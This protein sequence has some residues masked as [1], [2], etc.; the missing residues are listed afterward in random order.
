MKQITFGDLQS[1]RKQRISFEHMA[2]WMDIKDTWNVDERVYG[3]I[4]ELLRVQA[5]TAI[6]EMH[7]DKAVP[8]VVLPD[9]V[10]YQGASFNQI[11]KDVYPEGIFVND[12][13]WGYT[14]GEPVKAFGLTISHWSERESALLNDQW[15]INTDTPDRDCLEM[16]PTSPDKASIEVCTKSLVDNGVLMIVSKGHVILPGSVRYYLDKYVQVFCDVYIK[17]YDVSLLLGYRSPKPNNK[18]T[19]SVIESLAELEQSLTSAVRVPTATSDP[20]PL[21]TKPWN[22]HMKVP[23]CYEEE[24]TI[25]RSGNKVKLVFKEEESALY[26]VGSVLSQD[27]DPAWFKAT[28][29]L[30]ERYNFHNYARLKTEGRSLQSIML[31]R[32]DISLTEDPSVSSFI[33]RLQKTTRSSQLAYP[34]NS[35]VDRQYWSIGPGATIRSKDKKYKVLYSEADVVT[36]KPPKVT[37]EEVTDAV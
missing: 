27:I 16:S 4:F 3:K 35:D 36:H 28:A 12:N 33:R 11:L 22:I 26:W 19:P 32:D 1:A 20:R 24:N 13:V 6:L 9:G 8:T 17:E 18:L 7:A 14:R 31:L 21:K 15:T 23:E 30:S 34:Q 10:F 29:L 25:V 37:M 5:G 2:Q